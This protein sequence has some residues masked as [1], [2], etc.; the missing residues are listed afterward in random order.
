MTLP[1]GIITSEVEG[2]PR[3]RWVAAFLKLRDVLDFTKARRWAEAMESSERTLADS[4]DNVLTEDVRQL[5]HYVRGPDRLLTWASMAQE[6]LERQPDIARPTSAGFDEAVERLRQEIAITPTPI[7][8]WGRIALLGLLGAGVFQ[9]AVQFFLG[10]GLGWVAFALGLLAAAGCGAWIVEKAHAKLL[11][12]LYAAQEALSRRYE[13]QGVENLILLLD[14][15]R[16]RLLARIEEEVARVRAQA[17]A[18]ITI[19]D[20]EKQY[21]DPQELRG[22]VNVEWVIPA[23]LRP[24]WLEWLAPPWTNLHE[25]AARAGRLVPAPPDGPTC[26]QETSEILR[27][28]GRSY[29]LGRLAEFG[30]A[31]LMEFRS[32]AEQ[33]FAERIVRDLDRRAAALAP[34][35]PRRTVWRGPGHVLARI[36][37]VAVEL[38]ADASEN[39]TELEMLACLK[40]E[41][42]PL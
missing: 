15:L 10:S 9:Y 12:A 16:G 17:A 33:G 39:S 14:R 20:S 8:V 34:R 6:I 37:E 25:E 24:R 29:L 36:R 4:L 35:A 27:S 2:L 22:V 32:M 1:P 28:F 42:A 3:R 19:A 38:D 41:T 18:A 7:A 13:A 40:V 26:M 21:V 5:H 31:G 11:A 23:A 30:L